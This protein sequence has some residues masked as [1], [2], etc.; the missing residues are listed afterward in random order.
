MGR[1]VKSLNISDLK[2]NSNME[3]DLSELSSAIYL[4][5][6]QFENEVLFRKIEKQ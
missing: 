3:L 4:I 5:K 6:F 1:T 2:L